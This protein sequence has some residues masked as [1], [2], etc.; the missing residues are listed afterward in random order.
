MTALLL[1]NLEYI[2]QFS[3]F[4]FYFA[5]NSLLLVRLYQLYWNIYK[6]LS[7]VYIDSFFLLCINCFLQPALHIYFKG[8]HQVS[9]IDLSESTFRYTQLFS[10]GPFIAPL[11]VYS[12]FSCHIFI[13]FSSITS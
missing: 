6:M 3:R 11:L 12:H 9:L 5:D 1:Y 4:L 8:Y 13:L 10:L 2:L 7:A